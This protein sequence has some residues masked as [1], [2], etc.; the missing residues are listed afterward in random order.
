MKG[1]IA[2]AELHF[3]R[4][5]LQ[6]GKLNKAQKGQ[7]RFPLPVGFSYDDAGNIETRR[8]A[9]SGGCAAGR[10][11]YEEVDPS[12][13]FGEQTVQQIAERFSVS[14]GVVYY[15]IE[16]GLLQARRKNNGS[17]YW[18]SLDPAKEAELENWILNSSR[19]NQNV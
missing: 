16:R 14:R 8:C 2:Q 3:M 13:R 1:T 19:I 4:A 9:A 11:P 12:N 10:T 15:W 5:R 18:I 17:P 7:L 6:G